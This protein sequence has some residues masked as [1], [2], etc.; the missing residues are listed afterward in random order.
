M[1]AVLADGRAWTT[2]EL[3]MRSGVD[4]AAAADAVEALIARGGAE[5]LPGR[6]GYVRRPGATWSPDGFDG[7]PSPG[8]R[9]AG[10]E[11]ATGRSC[12]RHL[13]GDLGLAVTTAWHT[14]GVFEEDWAVTDDGREWF[15]A[16]GVDVDGGDIRHPR[17]PDLRPCLDWTRRRDHAAGRLADAFLTHG[18]DAGWFARGRH[19]RAVHATAGGRTALLALGVDVP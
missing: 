15:A 12:Y 16:A 18:L 6:H 17:H 13:A 4:A 5:R 2:A 10:T 14:M 8:A 1:R 9:R 19:P 11:L 7:A 3:A